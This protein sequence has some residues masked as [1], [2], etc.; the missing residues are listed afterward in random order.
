MG[1]HRRHRLRAT[2]PRRDGSVVH[3]VGG[4]LRARQRAVDQQLAV[5]E[6]GDDL[7]RPYDD[8]RRHRPAGTSQRDPGVESAELPARTGEKGY[9]FEYGDNRRDHTRRRA[10]GTGRPREPW[11]FLIVAHGEG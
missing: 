2:K 5:L 10:A 4:A 11:G 9:R 7:Q 3:A 6:M 1:Y 8:G